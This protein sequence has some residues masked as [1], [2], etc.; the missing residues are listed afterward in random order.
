VDINGTAGELD[1][2]TIRR[3]ILKSK[4]N[5]GQL[6]DIGVH[7]VHL[8][9]QEGLLSTAPDLS[10]GHPLAEK[11][12]A[13][14]WELII[15]GIYTPGT[16]MQTPNLPFVRVTAYGRK[17]FE[18]GELTAHDPDDYLRR[19]KAMCPSID[20]TT[21]LYTGEALDTFRVGKHLAATVMIGVAAESMLLRLV[22][23]VH[24]ALDTVQR[25]AKFEKD[26]KG[27]G[28]RTQ[29]DEVLKVLRSSANPLPAKL[30]YVLTQQIDGIYDLIRRTRNEAGHPTGRRLEREEAHALLLLFPTYCKTVHDLMEWLATNTI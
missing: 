19:L 23:A 13:V 3:L 12:T 27:K 4:L 2:A 18:A 9:M 22:A 15:E 30:G 17:C 7:V 8:A 11:I 6:S 28:A 10:Y 24:S 20:E 29:H 5:G 21:L 14:V 16:G 1:S 25:R 26:T